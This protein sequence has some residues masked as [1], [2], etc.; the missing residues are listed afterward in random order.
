MVSTGE[1]G[2]TPGF[3]FSVLGPSFRRLESEASYVG[4]RVDVLLA[5]R[6]LVMRQFA[7]SLRG[8][9]VALNIPGASRDTWV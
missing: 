1:G 4:D 8:T 5:S 6:S 7:R 9:R 3:G 2:Q